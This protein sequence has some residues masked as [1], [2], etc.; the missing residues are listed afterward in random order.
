M[1]DSTDKNFYIQGGSTYDETFW[2]GK[3]RYMSTSAAR[4]WVYDLRDAAGCI[5]W[6]RTC[7][8]RFWETWYNSWNY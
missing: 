6:S 7:E 1:I 5:N 4:Q 2:W 8:C 3:R